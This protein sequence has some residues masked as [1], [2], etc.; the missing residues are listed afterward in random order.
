MAGIKEQL[1]ILIQLQNI[2]KEIYDL[3][4]TLADKPREEEAILKVFEEKERLFKELEEKSKQKKIK[5]K[6][7]ELELKSKEENVKKLQIQLYQ[8]KTN[9]EYASMQ[10][11]IADLKADNSVLEEAIIK[12]MEVIDILDKE[13]GKEKVVLEEERKKMEEEVARVKKETEELKTRLNNLENSR[14]EFVSKIDLPILTRYE[15]LLENKNG[16]ALAQIIKDS[17]SGCN[18][19]LPPQVISEVRIGEKVVTC[20]NCMRI[21]YI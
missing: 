15:R 14:G 16:R 2:D 8:V 4:E 12:E 9:K 19:G 18:M 17:C 1:G 21:L 20:E 7:Q 10:K 5:L 13:I 6:E 3:R 11:E